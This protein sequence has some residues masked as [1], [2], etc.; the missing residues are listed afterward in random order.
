MSASLGLGQQVVGWEVGA[1]KVSGPGFG[2][3]LQ[4]LSAAGWC[5]VDFGS[6]AVLSAM[7]TVIVQADDFDTVFLAE[8]AGV[9]LEAEL[10]ALG[11]LEVASV[12]VEAPDN[13]AICAVDL[14]NCAGVTGRDEVVTLGVLVDAVNVEVVPC[15]RGVVSRT[16]LARVDWKNSL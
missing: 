12:A 6:A 11:H 5:S 13:G 1:D 4:D 16:C 15:V 14:V 9:V 2:V 10:G 7:G 8:P 3:E